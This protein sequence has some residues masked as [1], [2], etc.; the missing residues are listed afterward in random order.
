MK[1]S[2][3]PCPAW[4][5]R[6]CL[7]AGNSLPA[8]EQTE[9]QRHLAECAGCRAYH[10]EMKS[11][12]APLASW[13]KNFSQVQPD[14]MLQSRWRKAVLTAKHPESVRQFSFRLALRTSWRELIRPCRHAWAAMAAL[15]LLMLG[16][17]AAM[18]G[19]HPNFPGTHS[20]STSTAFPA[21]E[22]QR[23]V[24]AELIPP[25][26]GEPIEPPRRAHP[27]PR[28]QRTTRWSIG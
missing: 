21:F 18:S 25:I 11:L 12:T 17:N 5:E 1:R 2:S 9:V 6:V 23:R 16:I 27:Q 13:E 19:A 3:N 26:L 28:S 8:G 14:Q 20:S 10:E 15:W 4:R 22:E 7:L 24:L